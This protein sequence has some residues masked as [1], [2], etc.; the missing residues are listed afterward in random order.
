MTTTV[1][2]RMRGE[3]NPFEVLADIESR[4]IP[5]CAGNT[6]AL[7][8]KIGLRRGSSPHARGTRG[9]PGADIGGLR[10]IP[11]CA[12]NTPD[13]SIHRPRAAVHPRMRGE[14]W[15]NIAIGFGINGSS[16]HARGTH[17]RA[18]AIDVRDRFIPACAGNTRNTLIT[19]DQGPVHPRMR[20]EHQ[21]RKIYE[22]D[23]S[24]SS[25]HA[26]GTHLD[27]RADNRRLRFIPACAGNT[28]VR[29]LWSRW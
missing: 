26:R 3:H 9:R 4:F 19:T 14:H 28:A 8:S 21:Y 22:H 7:V 10:F 15:T 12:G 6:A 13:F 23:A 18:D 2:P 5:A 11:A 29:P 17:H 1:H 27:S 20:G 16:P 25:P 24:G